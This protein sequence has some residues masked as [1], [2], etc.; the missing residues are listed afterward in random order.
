VPRKDVCP[1]PRVSQ[2]QSVP[3]A[4]CPRSRVS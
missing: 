1:P 4:E 2:E 3:G